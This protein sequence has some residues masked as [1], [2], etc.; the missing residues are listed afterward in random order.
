MHRF[1]LFS[2]PHSETGFTDDWSE[3]WIG[4]SISQWLCVTPARRH[5]AQGGWVGEPGAVPADS[6]GPVLQ[7]EDS[8]QMPQQVHAPARRSPPTPVPALIPV[9]L[10]PAFLPF[11]GKTDNKSYDSSLTYIVFFPF[12]RW[13]KKMHF[14]KSK[15]QWGTTSY[16]SKWPSLNAYK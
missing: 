11:L 15:L 16:Q 3:A 13:K 6:S 9:L 1:L 12:W 10:P 14:S 8:P 2:W 7:R 5:P 4:S